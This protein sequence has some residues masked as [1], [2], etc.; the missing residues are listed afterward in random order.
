MEKEEIG[1][2]G[3][4]EGGKGGK[5]HCAPKVYIKYIKFVHPM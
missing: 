3:R 4:K 1:S 5:N 2:D